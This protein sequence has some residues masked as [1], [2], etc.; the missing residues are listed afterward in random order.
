MCVQIHAMKKRGKDLLKFH[1]TFDGVFS[2]F[3][4]LANYLAGTQTT[5]C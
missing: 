3:I 5:A 1:G 4:R 2:V